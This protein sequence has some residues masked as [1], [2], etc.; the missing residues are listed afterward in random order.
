MKKISESQ[1]SSNDILNWLL[2]F[3]TKSIVTEPDFIRST[4]S[5]HL[6]TLYKEEPEYA[7]A[8]NLSLL[9][10]DPSVYQGTMMSPVIEM[11]DKIKSTDFFSHFI[12]HGST[13]DLSV[14]PGWSD[15][16]ALAVVKSS[17]L[18]NDRFEEF[19]KLCVD[20]D[21]QMR[22]IDKFQHHGIH[23]IHEHEL[24]SY[25]QLYLPKELLSYGKCLV[26]TDTLFLSSVDSSENELKRFKGIV[27]MLK[28]ASDS[29]TLFH[30]GLNGS[31]LRE[32]F[33]DEN[34]M[35]QL[36]YFLCVIM[37]IPS[38]WLNL[39]GEY[40]SKAD[41]FEMIRKYFDKEDLEIIEKASTI[42]SMWGINSESS[43]IEDNKIPDWVQG[44]LE[45]DYFSRAYKLSKML[46][47]N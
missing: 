11:A 27:R 42:R 4:F 34:T 29:G 20:L 24:L 22:R 45:K 16:D 9:K 8:E 13:S 21:K 1:L 47:E 10:F 6:S 38:L 17:A 3:K 35:Y 32:D 28:T 15:F 7:S 18:K 12:I 43:N 41:S 44:I 30:H 14:I 37:L 23:Y 36:K 46:L 39:K 26:G 33:K 31:F 25:P 2:Q 19:F 40:C 5:N